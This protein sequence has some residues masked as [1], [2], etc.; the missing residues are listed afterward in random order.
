MFKVPSISTQ[1]G[2]QSQKSTPLIHCRTD[3]VIQ[4]APL[5][6]YQSLRQVVDVNE[7]LS[8]R[9]AH[10]GLAGRR[11]Y[12]R[13][14]WGP[15]YL[16]V[17]GRRILFLFMQ[18]LRKHW[19][20]CWQGVLLTYT[21]AIYTVAMLETAIVEHVFYEKHYVYLRNG[22]ANCEVSHTHYTFM[23]FQDTETIMAIFFYSYSYFEKFM[24]IFYGNG[25]FRNIWH[26]TEKKM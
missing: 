18:K 25:F 4:V 6:L 22:E 13:L 26:N 8:G 14:D 7:F 20:Q 19:R 24:G 21:Y 11:S 2:S 10:V 12:S 5:D 15:Y 1:A 9:H 3:D 17:F 23:V 16:E